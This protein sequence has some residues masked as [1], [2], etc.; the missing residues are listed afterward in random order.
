MPLRAVLTSRRALCTRFACFPVAHQAMQCDRDAGE[1]PYECDPVKTCISSVQ[2]AKEALQQF[3]LHNTTVTLRV[4]VTKLATASS[5]HGRCCPWSRCDQALP[6]P[7]AVTVA[8][9]AVIRLAEAQSAAVLAGTCSVSPIVTGSSD[10]VFGC[11]CIDCYHIHR[12]A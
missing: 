7:A 1:V 11:N 8:S 9:F 2:L 10:M 6:R 3:G 5:G 4:A 12:C